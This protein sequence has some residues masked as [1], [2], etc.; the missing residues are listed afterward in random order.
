MIYINHRIN[1]REDLNKV[2][3]ENGAEVD[4]RYHENSLILHHDPFHHHENNPEKFED[5]CKNWNKDGPMI[6]NIKTEGVEQHCIDL[7]NRYQIKDW[8]F[9]DMSMPFFVI[10]ADCALE[11]SIKGLSPKNL[12]VRFSEREPI[13]YAL[14]FKDKALW[15]WV[16]CFSKLF[17]DKETSQKLKEANFNICLVSPELQGHPVSFID[18]FK[19]QCRYLSIDA[20]CTKYPNL[21]KS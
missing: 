14:S 4:I 1:T 10:Y 2:P 19:E 18:N 11:G 20:I 6:L 9:L 7:M 17:L 16:D 21:W 13:E 15:V 5:F 8:F 12:A 3:K